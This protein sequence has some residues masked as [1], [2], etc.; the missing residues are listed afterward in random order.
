VTTLGRISTVV[1][2]AGLAAAAVLTRDSGGAPQDGGSP[3][4]DLPRVVDL[5]SQLCIPC[6]TMMTELERLGTMTEG[7]LA[8]EFIDVNEDPSAAQAYGIRVIPTQIFLSGTGEE[9]WRHEGVISAEDMVAKWGELG[10]Q[11]IP[12]Q[13]VE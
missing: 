8:I 7:L 2:V 3:A 12:E 9:L 1:V 10:F 13:A 4:G 6:R 11:V 5:G